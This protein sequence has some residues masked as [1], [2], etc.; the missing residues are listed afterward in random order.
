MAIEVKK[1][2]ELPRAE[3]VSDSD[4]V[5]IIQAGET[6]IVRKNLISSGS[7]GG[8]SDLNSA[9]EIV[10]AGSASIVL[11]AGTLISKVRFGVASIPPLPLVYH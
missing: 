2:S 4:D 6:K 1:G 8:G 5:F 7:G 9:V 3:S 10:C 11:E